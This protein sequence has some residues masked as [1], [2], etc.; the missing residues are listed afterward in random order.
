MLRADACVVLHRW[1]CVGCACHDRVDDW[2]SGNDDVELECC[3]GRDV[4]SVG[5]GGCWL[6][7][8]AARCSSGSTCASSAEACST[9]LALQ[10]VAFGCHFASSI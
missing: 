7:A 4:G 1:R 9:A 6:E 2:R 10:V 5:D 8:A 3:S